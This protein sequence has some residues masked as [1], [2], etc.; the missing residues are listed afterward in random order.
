[1]RNDKSGRRDP[2]VTLAA[3]RAFAVVVESGGFSTAAAA[4]GLSQPSVSAQVQNLEDATG[5]RLLHRRGRLE[6][7]EDGRA[8]L[9]RARLVL[10]RVEEFQ[11]SVQ[12]IRGLRRGRLA[13]GFS[14][15]NIT[16]PLL[17]RYTAA[18][19]AIEILTSTGNT[20]SLLADVA[21]C[22]ID[23][24]M[25]TLDAPPASL[26]H[27]LLATQ[28]L[29]LC[30]RDDDAWAKRRTVRGA[31]LAGAGVILRET[32]S[33]TRAM[34]EAACARA[35]VTPDVRLVV[36]SR[37]AL[38]E[39]VAA[40]LGRGTVLDT[41]IGNDH[42]LRFVQLRDPV[43]E[44][45]AYAVALNEMAEIPAVAAFLALTAQP[46]AGRRQRST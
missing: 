29:G 3:L 25:M 22:R 7:T 44:A 38:K 27:R 31:D 32:G 37:E 43:A 30:V 6:L 5:L 34:F 1:M 45:G 13:V 20:A 41:E 12:D 26:A 11:H 39:A 36:P 46:A 42:R 28:R 15:P 14:T 9:L 2:G 19:P 21:E 35:G 16:M 18:H 4:L 23:I 24:G 10:S 8:L 17:A 33:M 40:G